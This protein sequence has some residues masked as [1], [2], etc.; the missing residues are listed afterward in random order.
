MVGNY[1]Y[2]SKWHMGPLKWL[3]W[4]Q[5]I[6]YISYDFSKAGYF[7]TAQVERSS[8]RPSLGPPLSA[9]SPLN[10]CFSQLGWFAFSESQSPAGCCWLVVVCQ[11]PLCTLNFSLECPPL[12]A[13][14]CYF[15]DFALIFHLAAPF[16]NFCT[17][18]TAGE[19]S[20]AD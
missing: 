2:M 7:P 4:A 12:S 6:R 3:T 20:S 19:D 14:C 16:P 15:S 9:S 10:P 17:S 13:W 8:V 1:T 18:Y 11:I 5:L